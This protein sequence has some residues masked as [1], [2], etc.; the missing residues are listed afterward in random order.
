MPRLTSVGVLACILLL[1]TWLGMPWKKRNQGT[2]SPNSAMVKIAC[3]F[4]RVGRP[5]EAF[6]NCLDVPEKILSANNPSKTSPKY[7]KYP[8]ISSFQTW[9]TRRSTFQSPLIR[10]KGPDLC[11]TSLEGNVA[12]FQSQSREPRRPCPRNPT[13]ATHDTP[14]VCRRSV[15]KKNP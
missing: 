14:V 8:I 9:I 5:L 6:K 3:A 12:Y 4:W 7:L 10:H 2:S 11:A 13:K 15:I 1:E